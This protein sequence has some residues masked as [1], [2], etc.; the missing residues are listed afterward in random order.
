MTILL[1]ITFNLLFFWQAWSNP[2]SLATSELLSTF[3]PSWIH[4]GRGEKNDPYYWI[5]DSVHP[6]VSF[7][8]FPSRM[9]SRISSK[10]A[11][12]TRFRILVFSLLIHVLCGSVGWLLLFSEFTNPLIALF[13]AITLNYA[14]YN[15]K[16]QP[17]FLYTVAWFPFLL[18]GIAKGSILLSSVSFGMILLAGY[19]PIG[20][21]ATLIAVCASVWWDSPLTWLPIGTLVGLPQLIPFLRYLP[22]TIRTNKV[23]SIG[24]VKLSHLFTLIFP[25]FNKPKD[26]GFWETSCYVGI[27]PLVLIA[28]SKVTS[29]VW[30]L[31]VAS[32]LLAMGAFSSHLPRIPARWL[33]AFQFALGFMAIAALQNLSLS[34][35]VVFCLSIIQGFDLW[36]HNR[37]WP[38]RP[39]AEIPN[40]PSFAFNTELT[41]FLECTKERVS[42]LPW[43]LFTGHIN[44]IKTLGYS[45]GM[46]LKLMAKWRHDSNPNGAGEHDYFRSNNDM[47]ALN[48]YRVKWAFSRKKLGL[49]SAGVKNLYIIPTS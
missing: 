18:L 49:S 39:Y 45:G 20:I 29:Q 5:V 4:Q 37:L 26:M 47:E 22:K 35:T 33:W 7:Y 42:G 41:R 25:R 15:I 6:V 40:R 30:V 16:Q 1:L 12:D 32:F 10:M 27:V 36:Y 31:G 23:S 48:R 8:Y 21:Q 11:I 13:G 38:T 43:P 9:L 28:S 2:F 44:R 17:C 24:K 3:F 14:S 46:Q 19:Y 34:N